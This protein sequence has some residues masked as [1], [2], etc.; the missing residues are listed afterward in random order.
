MGCV[1]GFPAVPDVCHATSGRS[2]GWSTASRSECWRARRRRLAGDIVTIVL[3][4]VLEL[5]RQLS[6]DVGH[7]V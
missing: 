1:Q 6:H 3:A 7:V 4:V 2:I 5:S